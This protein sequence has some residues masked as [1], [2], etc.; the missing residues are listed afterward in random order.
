MTQAQPP[1]APPVPPKKKSKKWLLVLAFILVA[2]LAF[3]AAYYWQSQQ[4]K[5]AQAKAEASAKEVASLQ[6]QLKDSQAETE[7]A[8]AD[9]KAE[10]STEPASDTTA[11]LIPGDVETTRTDG[12]I[13]V[14]TVFKYSLAPTAVWVE[15]GT[16]PSKL[17]KSTSKVTS[18]LG[19]GE[20]GAEYA[21]GVSTS[22]QKSDVTAGTTY[23]YRVAATVGGKTVYSAPASFVTVK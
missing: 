5:D 6:Q 13:L 16:S 22:I 14:A 8:K 9:A 19:A 2:G 20:A 1:A 10:E 7:K 4:T 23:Y 12:R 18:G 15:Y 17:D 3:G 21:T 11:D